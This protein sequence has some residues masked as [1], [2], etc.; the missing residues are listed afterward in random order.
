MAACLPVVA[1]P[2]GDVPAILQDGRSGFLVPHGDAQS[3]AR[4]L[5]YLAAHPEQRR[6]MG[7]AGR[8]RVEDA[9]Q[10]SGLAP[11]LLE[12][13]TAIAGWRGDGVLLRLLGQLQR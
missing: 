2:A 3:L 6:R 13:Y 7:Q 12:L 9:Y 4:S 1:T 11:R 8:Q 5:V 10:I